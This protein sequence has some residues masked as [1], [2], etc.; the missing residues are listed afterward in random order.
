MKRVYLHSAGFEVEDL[1]ASL[2]TKGRRSL[3]REEN[4]TK[5]VG[6]GQRK[7]EGEKVVG[8]EYHMSHHQHI[9]EVGGWQKEGNVD[10]GTLKSRVQQVS[11]TV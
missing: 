1:Q 9:Q 11:P 8:G 7:R 3:E 4:K 6:T 5:R 2:S 10:T